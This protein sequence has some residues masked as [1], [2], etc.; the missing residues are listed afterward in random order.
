MNDNDKTQFPLEYSKTRKNNAI[1][2]FIEYELNGCLL[3]PKQK[4]TNSLKSLIDYL[5]KIDSS[6][7]FL[8]LCNYAFHIIDFSLVS[9]FIFPLA[10][11]KLF[12]IISFFIN[13]FYRCIFKPY[14]IQHNIARFDSK[15]LR[16]ND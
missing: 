3:D 5:F 7:H 1:S 10:Y 16:W 13:H 12:Y 11:N 8:N 9:C 2:N 4:F 6:K 14:S 15:I